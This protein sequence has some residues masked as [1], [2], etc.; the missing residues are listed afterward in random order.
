M[1]FNS[2]DFF[3]FLIIVF[4]IYWF[5]LDGKRKWQNLFILVASYVFYAWWDWRFL[6]L[7]IISSVTDYII[8]SQ[9]NKTGNISR[10]KLLLTTSLLVNLGIL[11][12][13][14][15]SNFFIESF[16]DLATAFGFN[17]DVH[18]LRIILPVG[19]SFYTFQTLSYTIDIYR[20]E[21]KPTNDILAFMAYVSFFPQLVAGPIERASSLVPQ[22]EK[23]RKFNVDQAKNGLR[24]M[25][26][27]LFLKV[28]IADSCGN[29]VNIIFSDYSN[30][31]PVSL[32]LGAIYF[33]F[34]IYGD[35]AGYSFVAIGTGKLLGFELMQNFNYPYF[36]QN[37]TEFWRR[38]HISLST[39]IK[40][41]LFTPMAISFRNYGKFGLSLAS[42]LSFT[43]IGFWHGANWNFIVFGLL[44]GIALAFEVLT[45]KWRKKIKK[46]TPKPVYS[47]FSWFL[48]MVFWIITLIF[49]RSEN[50][51][52][53]MGYLSGILSSDMFSL[54]HSFLKGGILISL[55]VIIEIVFL[56]KEIPLY[57]PRFGRIGN[58]SLYMFAG[59]LIF[60]YFQTEGNEFIYF[61]F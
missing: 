31:Q 12:Y 26:W 28:V 41:Y 9:L 14:K 30:M 4:A 8:G 29:Y 24:Y 53:A 15:Y 3:I 1:F 13:F 51:S 61:Q 40:D 56:G 50:V 46:H 32:V 6:S 10:R 16:Q 57:H 58:W 35:F 52:N 21:L 42:I 11:V 37:I 44:H 34:Q 59:C 18:T 47:G 17:T 7:I 2:I 38:W 45:K 39:W 22:F 49:F 33:T 25:L 5:I 19:I 23:E 54:P 27:G 36:S 55:L 60:L 48:T 43:T 20:K